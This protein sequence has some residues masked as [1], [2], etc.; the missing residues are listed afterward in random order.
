MDQRQALLQQA[1]DIVK[2]MLALA[3]EADEKRLDDGCRVLFGVMRDCA[4][5]IQQEL[6]RQQAHI[7]KGC[8]AKKR[9]AP[10][11]VVTKN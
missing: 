1:G 2:A 3:S 6:E 4:Y 7:C 11:A 5:R 10:D 9:K 8:M